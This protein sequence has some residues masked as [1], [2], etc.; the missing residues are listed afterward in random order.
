[1]LHQLVRRL[2][3]L[4]TFLDD[5]YDINHGGCCLIAYFIAKHLD[6]LNIKY[7]LII[8]DLEE[9]NVISINN[10]I[11]NNI[12]ETDLTCN[13]YYLKIID[14][15]ESINEGTFD[16]RYYKYNVSIDNCEVIKKIY[17]FGDW[18]EQYNNEYS[19]IIDSIINSF[20]TIYED[21]NFY[22]GRKMSK[23]WSSF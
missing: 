17:E 16:D 5:S 20:F 15:N 10:N 23:M 13:H 14:T 4:C 3:S 2:N 11:K 22:E 18:N 7:D 6:L 9:E 8:C 21:C 19:K 12:I 1:M